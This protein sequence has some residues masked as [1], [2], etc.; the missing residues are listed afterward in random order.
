MKPNPWMPNSRPEVLEEMLKAIGVRTVDE[1][2]S[3]I[4]DEARFRG[5]WDKLPIGKGRMLS[6]NEVA[7]ILEEKL[8]KVKTFKPA[9]FMGAGVYP[10]YTPEPVKWVLSLGEILTAYTPYQAE[11]NQGLMQLL[12]EYQ[13][14]M[15]DLLEME[16]VNSSMYDWST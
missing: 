12:F 8:S 4:P 1:L 14:L 9:P 16:V 2:Y 3:D 11:I 15:A 5:E 13:S 6:E 7:E 10:V